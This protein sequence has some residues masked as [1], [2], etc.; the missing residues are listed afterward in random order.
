[1]EQS[2]VLRKVSVEMPEGASLKV[3]VAAREPATGITEENL[4]RFSSDS[5][6]TLPDMGARQKDPTVTSRVMD[7]ASL[8]TDVVVRGRNAVRG[9]GRKI[10]AT[11]AATL[12]LTGATVGVSTIT[13]S[14]TQDKIEYQQL[15]NE[16]SGFS[17]AD[18][19]RS[20]NGKQ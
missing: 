17:D 11:S 12:A 8:A 19:I 13:K 6:T 20:E 7:V 4:L 1:M 18:A 5:A 10:A 3:D 9:R 16:R 2:S 14:D 15:V